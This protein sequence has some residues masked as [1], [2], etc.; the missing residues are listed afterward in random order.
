MTSFEARN[1]LIGVTGSV[2]AI[3][4]INL[5]EGLR[6]FFGS[7][8]SIKKHH[9]EKLCV[10]IIR[11]QNSRHFVHKDHLLNHFNSTGD[12]PLVEI[13][14]DE[15]EWTQWKQMNDPVLHI[16]LRKW[17]QLLVIAPLDANTMAKIANGICDNLLTCV[18]RAWD[19]SKPLLYC[20]AMNVHMYE[21]PITKDHLS[22]LQSL[23]YLRV[24]CIEKRLACG[25]VGIGGMAAIETIVEK[26][27]E[28]LLNDEGANT[29]TEGTIKMDSFI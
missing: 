7:S 16:E 6:S 20:P 8:S 3:K 1:I 29:I 5:V 15:D 26:I 2:A 22:K 12:S 28:C 25:D 17:A 18:V 10:K 24:D 11:T 4:L 21:H 19:M 23:G 13:Y 27:G 14:D 9:D